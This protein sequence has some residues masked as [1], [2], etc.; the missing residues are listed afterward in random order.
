MAL[1]LAQK[2]GLDNF[3]EIDEDLD[4]GKKC[5]LCCGLELGNNILGG[6]IFLGAIF[7]TINLIK[8]FS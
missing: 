7:Y 5:C 1:N 2:I 3:K 4:E 6:L 8:I